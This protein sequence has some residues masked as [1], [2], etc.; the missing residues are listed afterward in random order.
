[1]ELYF[2]FSRCPSRLGLQN[3]PTASQQSGKTPPLS[4]QDMAYKH[5]NSESEVMLELWETRNTP[6]LPSL[7]GSLWPGMVASDRVR[8]IGQIELF[9]I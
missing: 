1:M 8:S 4:V 2:T 7:P 6:S 5:S 9:D 3:T